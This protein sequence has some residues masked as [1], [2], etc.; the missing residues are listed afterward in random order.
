AHFTYGDTTL[1][2][3]S[4][5]VEIRH[6]PQTGWELA[7][8]D[9]AA[10]GGGATLS[11]AVT[12]SAGAYDVYFAFSKDEPVTEDSV[13]AAGEVVAGSGEAYSKILSGLEENCTYHYGFA[14]VADGAVQA[15]RSGTFFTSDYSYIYASG[16]WQ[17][18]TPASGNGEGESMLFA[19]SYNWAGELHVDGKVAR[20]A[21]LTATTF[22]QAADADAQAMS[23]VDAQVASMR[24]SDNTAVMDQVPYGLYA[25][26]GNNKFF[27]FV[28]TAVA[29]N[30]V[31]PACSYTCYMKDDQVDGI[32]SALLASGKITVGGAIPSIDMFEIVDTGVLRSVEDTVYKAVKITLFDTIPTSASGTWTLRENAY[33]KLAG[34]TMIRGLSIGA[35]ATL[36]LAGHTLTLPEGTLANNGTIKENGGSIEYVAADA[37]ATLAADDFEA[38]NNWSA[39]VRIA[40]E[41]AQPAT[42]WPIASATHEN[43]LE[44]AG[45]AERTIANAEAGAD[46]E[47]DMLVK[48]VRA[49]AEEAPADEVKDGDEQPQIALTFDAAGHAQIYCHDETRGGAFATVGGTAYADGEW[50]R[51]TMVFD[52]VNRSCQ[53]MINGKPLASAAGYA[54]QAL[55]TPFGAW[56]KLANQHKDKISSLVVKGSS[57]IDDVVVK[58]QAIDAYNP[59]KDASGRS[60]IYSASAGVD[61]PVTYLVENDISE[62]Q[63]EL[64][65]ETSGLTAAQAY[66]AG[67]DWNG[68]EKFIIKSGEFNGGKFRL[69]FPGTWDAATYTV[70]ISTIP[71]D[72]GEAAETTKISGGRGERENVVD[73]TLPDAP[74]VYF[75]VSR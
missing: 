65:S 18:A 13:V 22:L 49:G 15:F 31:Y 44:V 62:D 4:P 11:T 64:R 24:N 32:E 10:N 74:T 33:A 21:T 41:V 46:A 9:V 29:A 36:D 51:V 16:A 56:Y 17:G 63:L 71:G 27:D 23:V 59:Y 39:G 47:V 38:A 2:D 68:T 55:E 19:D 57:Q 14:V 26:G 43:V 58:N 5:A 53:V 66:V 52:Y 3:G 30:T 67:I 25:F 69:T 37:G 61:I 54:T 8:V 35:G 40:A 73:V 75:K 12:Q 48:V 45:E 70:S 42:G 20:G 72:V 34:D 1:E 28:H 60:V 50:V 6:V 7:N